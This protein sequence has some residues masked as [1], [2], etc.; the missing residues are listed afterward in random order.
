MKQVSSTMKKIYFLL[1]GLMMLVLLSCSSSHKTAGAPL[2]GVPDSLPTLPASEIDVPVKIAARPIFARAEAI[3]PMEFT[4][5]S[6]PNY[7]QP[8]CDFRYK[9]R[10]LRSAMAITCVNNK[11]GVQFLGN[12]QV[13]GGRCICSMN[14]PVSP[15]ISGSCG[16]GQEPMRKVN[17][18]INSQLSFLP[19]YQLRTLTRP[20][21]LQAIDKC[22]VSLFA[23][24]VTQQILDS[25][26]S[27][28][29]SFCNILDETIAGMNFSGVFQQTAAT[30][31]RKTPM[32]KYGYILINPKAIR[33]GQLNYAN[34]SFR[35]TLGISC[36]P[37]LSSDSNNN[38]VKTNLP[39]LEQK[40]GKSGAAIY[41][42]AEYD[43]DFLSKLLTDT[44]RNQVFDIKGRTIV[45]KEV[46]VKGNNDHEVE[47]KVGFAGS[48]SGSISL[49]G[50][51][52]LDT[53][54]QTLTLAN[55]SYSLESKDLILKMAKSVFRNKIRKTLEGG[56]YLDIAALVKSNQPFIDQQLNRK[57]NASTY[58]SGKVKEVKLIGLLVKQKSLRVQ[59]YANAD[60]SLLFNGLL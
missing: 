35:I 8:S 4:S 18:L 9:Y 43:Y 44:L 57:L 46:Q 27:S 10:F 28:V 29:A 60:I 31:Y 21:K 39:P 53:A 40:E 52:I 26:Q 3:V 22:Y 59:I 5:D 33:A 30:A 13:A 50:T 41:L 42:D 32:G 17:I 19:N 36:R 34:D 48:N 6:W 15:W 16:F 24:D 56:S 1:T 20:D 14:K 25:V 11:L 49:R 2:K 12:Y 51:P 54:R 38:H 7:L 55:I 47:I 58:S 37:Q 45:V 23:S